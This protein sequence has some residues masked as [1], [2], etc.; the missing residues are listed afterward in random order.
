MLDGYY[1]L[2]LIVDRLVD[3]TEATG[4]QLLEEGVLAC[5][6]A[7]RYIWPGFSG[8]DLAVEDG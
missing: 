4:P 3:G 6:I 7:A 5:R 8:P 2:R 1:L